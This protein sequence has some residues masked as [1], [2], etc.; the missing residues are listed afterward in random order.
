MAGLVKSLTLNKT[1]LVVCLLVLAY[2]FARDRFP[3]QIALLRI[4]VN[5]AIHSLL[6]LLVAA[7]LLS[8][9]IWLVVPPLI[10]VLGGPD[11]HAEGTEEYPDILPV[12]GDV[13]HDEESLVS[14]EH[15]LP[16]LS[17][18]AL[19]LIFCC[20]MFFTATCIMQPKAMPFILWDTIHLATRVVQNTLIAA[21]IIAGPPLVPCIPLIII[22]F[23]AKRLTV[24]PYKSSW[25]CTTSRYTR[26]IGG[27]F[28]YLLV[29]EVLTLYKLQLP[30]AILQHLAWQATPLAHCFKWL[31]LCAYA[32]TTMWFLTDKTA[33]SRYSWSSRSSQSRCLPPTIAVGGWS[34]S[35]GSLCSPSRW[36]AT[37]RKGLFLQ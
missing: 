15:G 2:V 32:A 21:A 12:S 14:I 7:R 28:L 10:S 4:F 31:G 36:S 35:C 33:R 6:H 20:I 37:A 13:A 27:S 11:V 18:V 30:P 5:F 17:F 34:N 25:S 8:A 22:W 3:E 1:Q 29:L 23:I 9:L 16:S 26:F 19:Y 24:E